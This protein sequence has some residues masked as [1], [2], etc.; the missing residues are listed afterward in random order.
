MFF[1]YFRTDNTI[2]DA[3]YNCLFNKEYFSEKVWAVEEGLT[4]EE[5]ANE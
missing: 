2:E 5:L 1:C 3:I 4:D